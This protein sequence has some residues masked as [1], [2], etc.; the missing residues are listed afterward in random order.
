MVQ[1]DSKVERRPAARLHLLH[2][3]N[4]QGRDQGARG[5]VPLRLHQQGVKEE[6]E[7]DKQV[8]STLL[9]VVLSIH[10]AGPCQHREP[11]QGSLQH[12]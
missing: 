2:L 3:A 4:Q 7:G 8:Q 1:V 10:K 11:H 5:G 12:S 9:V 6:Q